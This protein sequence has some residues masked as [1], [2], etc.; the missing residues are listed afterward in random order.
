MMRRAFWVCCLFLFACASRLSAQSLD[1]ELKALGMKASNGKM[2]Q[3]FLDMQPTLEDCK[4]VFT[5]DGAEKV[6]KY[7]DTVFALM[8]NPPEDMEEEDAAF[9]D[10]VSMSFTTEEALADPRILTGG[11]RASSSYLLPGVRWHQMRFLRN[12]GDEQGVTFRYF[13]KVGDHWVLFPKPWRALQ[14]R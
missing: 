9:V 14:N 5:A 3:A 4:A 11:M 1:D 2:S 13:V 7:C 8:R 10:A 12:V 6:F